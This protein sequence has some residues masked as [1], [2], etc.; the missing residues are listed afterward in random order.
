MSSTVNMDLAL[1][2]TSNIVPQEQLKSVLEGCVE[3]LGGV[4][5]KL[6]KEEFVQQV[7]MLI[8]LV[9]NLLLIKALIYG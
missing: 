8:Q 7:E 4:I 1:I 6:L 3:E 9:L 2:S 5:L